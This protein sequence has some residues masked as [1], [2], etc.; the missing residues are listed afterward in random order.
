M[1]GV[2][3]KGTLTTLV[4]ASHMRQFNA[5]MGLDWTSIVSMQA[6]IVK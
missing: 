2:V 1:Q 5:D 3:N 6:I 4:G